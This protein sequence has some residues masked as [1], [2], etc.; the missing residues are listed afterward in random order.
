ME[1][2]IIKIFIHLFK[3]FIKKKIIIIMKNRNEKIYYIVIFLRKNKIDI[4]TDKILY[5]RKK[6]Y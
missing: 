5:K 2:I 3:M 6:K 1:F 4:L